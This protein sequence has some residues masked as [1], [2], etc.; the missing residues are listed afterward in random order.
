MTNTLYAIPS[1]EDAAATKN[2]Q[3]NVGSFLKKAGFTLGGDPG[4]ATFQANYAS[5]V[6]TLWKKVRAALYEGKT[7]INVNGIVTSL[8]AALPVIMPF[9]IAAYFQEDTE[10]E[11]VQVDVD[12]YDGATGTVLCV[13]DGK[14]YFDWFN[15]HKGVKS[16]TYTNLLEKFQ[17]EYTKSST[18]T[19][20]DEDPRYSFYRQGGEIRKLSP[21][22]SV[23]AEEASTEEAPAGG[24][25]PNATPE[26]IQQYMQALEQ[27]ATGETAQTSTSFLNAEGRLEREEG[28]TGGQALARKLFSSGQEKAKSKGMSYH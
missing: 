4:S 9:A 6:D 26:E 24:L 28:E 13:K 14:L 10:H 16:K 19:A 7:S 22:G 11:G 8:D 12:N 1:S 5:A 21:G 15:N 17:E 20:S 2:Y 23:P 18:S 25:S 27:Q 3:N